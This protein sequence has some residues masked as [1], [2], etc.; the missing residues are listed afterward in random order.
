MSAASRSTKPVLRA[1]AVNGS[2][3]GAGK[4]PRVELETK[5]LPSQ[6]RSRNTFDAILRIAG[7]VLAEKGPDE[8]SINAVGQRSGLSPPAFYR[9]FPNKYALL[10][11]MAERLMKAENDAVLLAMSRNELP[12]READLIG[13]LRAVLS[14]LVTAMAAFPGSV[15]I[16]RALRVKQEMRHIQL[17]STTR[18]AA[19]RSER[20]HAM[21]PTA[22]PHRLRRGA[23]LGLETANIVSQLIVEAGY[24]EANGSAKA[25]IAE[26]AVMLGR[27]YWQLGAREEVVADKKKRK[28]LPGRG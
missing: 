5:T 16:L 25:T 9:Y 23:R 2:K 6:A 27:Y 13:E 17:A 18:V 26:A 28:A 24:A 19:R 15:Q 20:L 4:R 3:R 22:D 7:D 11:A 8:F 12:R 1:R 10:K 21:F 14:E